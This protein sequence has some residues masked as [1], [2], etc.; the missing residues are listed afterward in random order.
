MNP[1]ST[2]SAQE[3]KKS[4]LLCPPVNRCHPTVA[5]TGI[6]KRCHFTARVFD[7]LPDRRPDPDEIYRNTNNFELSIKALVTRIQYDM[8]SE[9]AAYNGVSIDDIRVL[10]ND[11]ILDRRGNTYFGDS[12]PTTFGAAAVDVDRGDVYFDRAGCDSDWIED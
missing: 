7:L 3:K 8:I 12:D 11:V 5:D 1:N 2:K 10:A 6:N 4:F 9:F